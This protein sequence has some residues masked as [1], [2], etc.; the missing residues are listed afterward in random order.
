MMIYNNNEHTCSLARLH[1][2]PHNPAQHTLIYYQ[3]MIIY[4][5]EHT[6]S[7]ARLHQAPHNITCSSNVIRAIIGVARRI[8][9]AQSYD[10]V[11]YT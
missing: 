11:S 4:N 5:N 6:C 7:L 2:A 9:R 3:C 8:E 10:T 1:Q